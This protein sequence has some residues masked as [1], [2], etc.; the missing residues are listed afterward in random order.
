M[1][2]KIAMKYEIAEHILQTYSLLD[3][4]EFN[5]LDEADVLCFLVEQEFLDIPLPYPADYDPT[6]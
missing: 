4:L 6:S 1:R 5:E 3:I 2:S